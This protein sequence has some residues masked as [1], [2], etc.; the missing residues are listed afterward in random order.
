M[1]TETNLE[2]TNLAKEK[3]EG[4]LKAFPYSMKNVNETLFEIIF[5]EAYL[6]GQQKEREDANV[7]LK[8]VTDITLT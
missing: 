1:I 6:A 7:F 5:I 2:I 4:F 3:Y 8:Q